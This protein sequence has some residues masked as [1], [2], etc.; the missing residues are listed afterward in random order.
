[1]DKKSTLW[2]A[3]SPAAA[4]QVARHFFHQLFARQSESHQALTR[5]ASELSTD[6][7]TKTGDNVEAS[8][9]FELAKNS[10][11]APTGSF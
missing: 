1:V 9:A 4:R 3:F 6:L 5:L 8:L 2:R 10:L 11:A 7:S